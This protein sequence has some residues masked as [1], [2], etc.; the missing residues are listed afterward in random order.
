VICV[1]DDQTA[2]KL[3]RVGGEFDG[4][5]P[6]TFMRRIYRAGRKAVPWAFFFAVATAVA[7]LVKGLYP[8]DL[9]QS[10][11][12]DFIDNVFDNRGVLWQRGCCW[13]R[14][15]GFSRSAASSS[16]PR[17]ASG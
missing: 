6:W 13:S 16:S 4:L 7:L 15:L 9:P 8:A 17:S 3:L 5:R 2:G 1:T 14:R 10:P 11:S 12:P